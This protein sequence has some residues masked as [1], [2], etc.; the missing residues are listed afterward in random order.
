M[1]AFLAGAATAL[2][3]LA[4][5]SGCE[6]NS[7][8]T[9]ASSSTRTTSTT[10]TSAQSTTGNGGSGGAGNGGMNG[11]GGGSFA[12]GDMN[13]MCDAD[14]I[15]VENIVYM[16]PTEEV[17]WSCADDPCAPGPLSCDCASQICGDGAL[18]CEVQGDV[19][20]CSSG[21]ICASPETPVATPMGERPIAD[22]SPGDLVYSLH[23][24]KVVAVP[25]L[26]ASRTRVHDHAVVEVS[27]KSGRVLRIS[28]MH[29][30]ADGRL[31]RELLPTDSLG[32][33]KIVG[34]ATLPYLPQYTYDILPASDSGTYFAAGALIGSTLKR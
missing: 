23:E 18:S 6:S 32:S 21:G 13:L 12:C 14:Q 5:W 34:V 24:G 15:C 8:T 9:G 28:G 20:V 17:T 26:H 4:V 30:T 33:E 3:F 16:G 7:N 22:L 19:L 31:F 2:T 29:P 25:V 11:A 1:K 27:L 10:T